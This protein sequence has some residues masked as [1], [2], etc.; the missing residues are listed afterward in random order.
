MQL[1][2]DPNHLEVYL[3]GRK[4]RTFVGI[5]TYNQN[6]NTFQF[7][8]DS[9]YQKSLKAMSIGPD[10]DIFKKKHV[11]AKKLFPS[12]S[13]R[14]P[15]RS[16]PA[17]EEY[18]RSQGI[19]ANEKNPI[20]LLGS[21]GRRGPSS[22][23]FEPVIRN[24]FSSDEIVKFRKNLGLTRNE[25]SIAFDIKE[26]TLQRLEL[27]R[28]TDQN[29]LKL[30]EIYLKFPEVALWQLQRHGSK[31]S[32]ESNNKLKFYFQSKIAQSVVIKK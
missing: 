4:R 14:I 16:N 24:N 13:D 17:Y 19:S 15:S 21:I 18:C 25:L 5:L 6:K 30:I 31:L 32:N 9:K 10:L 28:S 11:S 1:V 7:E 22:F 29:T 20:I 26:Q 2:V 12:F 27:K 8:Y 23:I 3:E